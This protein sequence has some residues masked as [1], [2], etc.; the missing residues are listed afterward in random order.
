MDMLERHYM[1]LPAIQL[2]TGCSPKYI[3]SPVRYIV[4]F[5]SGSIPIPS[6]HTTRVPLRS[7]VMF[8]VAVDVMHVP[9]LT[10][11]TLNWNGGSDITRPRS[12][13]RRDRTMSRDGTLHRCATEGTVQVNVTLSPGHGLSTLDCNWAPE[14]KREWQ[15]L[16]INLTGLNKW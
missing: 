16:D 9:V 6:W 13:G 5:W 11:V 3:I 10:S 15:L 14:T 7:A 2:L 8:T 4:M 1:K 12:P